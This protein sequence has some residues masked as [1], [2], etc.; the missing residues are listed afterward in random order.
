MEPLSWN[1]KHPHNTCFHCHVQ[2]KVA[3][4]D[5]TIADDNTP[6]DRVTAFL[7]ELAAINVNDD[8]TLNNL[9]PVAFKAMNNNVLHYV[10]MLKD[11]DHDKFKERM[12]K[13]MQGLAEARTY[14]IIPAAMLPP[15]TKPIQAIW[16]FRCKC[17]PDWTI[18]KWKACLCP[19]GGQQELGMNY[20][21]TYAPVVNWST[22]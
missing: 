13:E 7:V 16:S 11:R 5:A 2:A 20:W 12:K 4:H 6:L 21:E 15:N 1:V 22:V 8:R 9:D 17:L 18:S 3:A 19:H 14:E 10:Q